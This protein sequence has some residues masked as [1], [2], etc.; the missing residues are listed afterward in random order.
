MLD[1]KKEYQKAKEKAL[2]LMLNGQIAAYLKQLD[3]IDN[4]KLKLNVL[5]LSA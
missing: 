4:I 3:E 2:Q 1:L 5:R